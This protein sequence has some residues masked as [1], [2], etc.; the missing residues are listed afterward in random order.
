M[1]RALRRPPKR[2]RGTTAVEE[3]TPLMLSGEEKR[4]LILAHAASRA[5][6]RRDWGIGYSAAIVLSCLVIF[7]G[8]WLTLDRS[9]GVAKSPDGFIQSLTQTSQRFREEGGPQVKQ[10][11]NAL[12]AAAQALQDETTTSTTSTNE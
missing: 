1:P 5:K 6:Q 12:E 11:T 4:E 9:L 10:A 3:G 8:W 2:S 7:T